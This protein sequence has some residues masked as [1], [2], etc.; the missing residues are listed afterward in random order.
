[1]HLRISSIFMT[2]TM[3]AKKRESGNKRGLQAIYNE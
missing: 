1:M 3:T 2:Y